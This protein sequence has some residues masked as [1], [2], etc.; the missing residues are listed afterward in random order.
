MDVICHQNISMDRAAGTFGILL[1]PIEIKQIVFFCKKTGLAIISTLNDVQ[2]NIGNNYSGASWHRTI[3]TL[4][5][6]EK[7]CLIVVCPLFVA[8]CS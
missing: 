8:S 2:W 1:Q 4:T 7:Q 3:S 5:A 6:D